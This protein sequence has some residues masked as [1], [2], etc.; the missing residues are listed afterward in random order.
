MNADQ[1][2]GRWAQFKGELNKQSKFADDDLLQI[3]GDYQ[4]SQPTKYGDEKEEVRYWVD[5]RFERL[6]AEA[7][8][9]RKGRVI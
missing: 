1:F 8:A 4:K 9:A 5:R 7:E 3:E 6:E 2:K